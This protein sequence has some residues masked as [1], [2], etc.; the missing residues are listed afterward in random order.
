MGGSSPTS[1][2]PVVHIGV[3][4]WRYAPWRGTFYP[5][6][7][8]QRDELHHISRRMSSV[9][10][11]GSFYSLQ[12]PQSYLAWSAATPGD[13]VFAV[14]GGRFIT[15]MK[16]L[17]GV[18]TALANFFG[19]GVLALGEKLGPVLWQ[20][21][22][23]LSFDAA[24]VTAFLEQLPRTTGEAAALSLK[25]DERL[26]GRAWTTTDRCRPLRHALEA[27]HPS[28]GEPPSV[29]LLRR[30]DVALVVSDSA[31]TWPQLDE[32]TADFAYARLHGDAE[33][34]TSG[35]TPEAL[36][37]WANRVRRW[38]DDGRDV[39]VYFDNDVKV[40]APFDAIALAGLLGVGPAQPLRAAST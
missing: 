21:P 19:S 20:L 5:K 40:R 33:L 36:R 24:R 37:Q 7:L 18:E 12:R 6:G 23:V 13:F 26:E 39:Y 9:E 10:V 1:L 29:E 16:K 2:R 32:R 35:Y 38:R 14:K 11:N 4:G 3:S 30:Y 28:F 22:A 15:H 8:R 31:G 17:S 27:R 34:Y 25:H